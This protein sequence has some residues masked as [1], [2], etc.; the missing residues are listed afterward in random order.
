MNSPCR[1]VADAFAAGWNAPCEHGDPDPSACADCR[2]T[3]S[4]IRSL[5]VLLKGLTVPATAPPQV[6]RTAA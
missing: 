5:A 3:T 4:E 1:T 2:L 6:H